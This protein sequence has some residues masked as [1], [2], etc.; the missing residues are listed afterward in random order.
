MA[1]RKSARV[2]SIRTAPA[3]KP[4]RAEP[5]PVAPVIEDVGP[6]ESGERFA[7]VRRRAMQAKLVISGAA[8]VTFGVGIALARASYAGH[9]KRPLRPLAA[10]AGFVRIVR[11]NLLQA[12]IVAPAQAPPGASTSVS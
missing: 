9:S 6:G 10:P 7:P 8:L 3:P 1:K 2:P 4:R 11:Q 12:G 5:R